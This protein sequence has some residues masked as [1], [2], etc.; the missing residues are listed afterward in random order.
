MTELHCLAL[1]H[2]TDKGSHGYCPFYER[3]IG[4]LQ[5]LSITMIEIGAAEGCSLR[6]WREWMPKAKIY[7]LDTSEYTHDDEGITVFKGDQSKTEDLEK[8]VQ[9]VGNFHLVVDDGGHEPAKQIISFDFLWPKLVHDGWYVVEDL[10][11][12]KD[13]SRFT[14]T[15]DV[16]ELHMICEKGGDGILFLKKK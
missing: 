9:D 1:F 6:M 12:V 2:G 7:A 11:N 14:I 8:L 13:F 15:D 3:F 4:D 16:K 5:P 10:D